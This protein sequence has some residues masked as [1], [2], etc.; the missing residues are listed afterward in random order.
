MNRLIEISSRAAL[1]A[2]A[3]AL[4]LLANG[5]AQ[6]QEVQTARAGTDAAR[7]VYL[8]EIIVTA[9]K[10]TEVLSEVPQ[11]ITVLSNETLERQ[12]VDSFEEYLALVPG[13]SLVSPVAGQA[14]VTLRG[15]NTGGGGATVAVYVDEVPFGSSSGIANGA[16][17]AGAFDTFDV[18]RLEVLRGPQGTL[19]GAS[20]VGGL[21]KFVTNPPSTEGFEVNAQAGIESTK[22]GGIGYSATG[23]VN[24]PLGDTFA[25]R[26]S[27]FYRFDDGFIDSIGN[28]PLA[29]LTQPG[30]NVVAGTRVDD[31]IN[32]VKIYGGRISGLFTPSD[33]FSVRLTAILQNVESDDGN[34]F[35]ANAATRE[36]LYGGLVQSRYHPQFVNT[37]Y[38][39]YSGTVDWNLGFADLLSSTSYGTLEQDALIDQ[40]TLAPLVTFFA[41]IG[42]FGNVPT[43][44]PLS[45]IRV[46]G[47]STKKFTQELR[48]S[49]PDNESL[50][51]LVGAYYSR[52]KSAIDPQDLVAVEAGTETIAPDLPTLQDVFLKSTYEEYAAFANATWHL[53]PRFDLTFGGR[54]SHNKQVASQVIDT[55]ALGGTRTAFADQRSSEDVFTWS[56]APRFEI[57][58]DAA[59]YARVATGYRAGGPNVLPPAPIPAPV[60]PLPPLPATF[61]SDT[62]TSYEVGLK[63]DWL[64]RT[65]SLDIA[66]YYLDWKDIQL[67][68]V[69]NNTAVVTNGGT[70]VSKGVE[71]TATARPSRGVTLSVNGAHTDA[72]LT[73]DTTLVTGGFNGDPLP[74]VPKWSLNLNGDYEWEVM[75]D[76]TAYVGATLSFISDRTADFRQ[77]VPDGTP[78]GRIREVPGYETIDLRAGIDAGRW[79]IRTYVR[80][81]LNTRGFNSVFGE[82]VSPGGT[83]MVSLGVIRPRTIGLTVGAK[84]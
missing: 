23:V 71:F 7:D 9:Q 51:W 44:R 41:S 74:Y 11:S 64:D 48:L 50:E 55:T 43:T 52:E 6:A 33:A 38:R 24:V 8:D 73:E 46:D 59:V 53:S 18:A 2:S 49:S 28:N 31:N 81:L 21:L 4:A 37:K 17:L 20:S 15:I 39:L 5:V 29:S 45:V 57:S 54:A 14:R 16:T 77:R 61:N 63:A 78:R 12:Q 83:E 67:V 35:E 80:N 22:G 75:D 47:V 79:S 25:I 30:V 70:A 72:Y 42:A 69:I 10:R 19:Y 1:A 60:P 32:S 82:G 26:A 40:G 13:L 34:F 84:F 65:F 62:L 76:A 58:D 56:V 27:G 36:S 66:A 3:G 68:T